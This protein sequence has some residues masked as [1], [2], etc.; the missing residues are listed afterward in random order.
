MPVSLR[1]GH[2]YTLLVLHPATA[3]HAV[4]HVCC[5]SRLDP[6][7]AGQRA[8]DRL[9]A[10]VPITATE[11]LFP[12]H[13]EESSRKISDPLHR[14]RNSSSRALNNNSETQHSS[15]TAP[16]R[17]VIPRNRPPEPPADQVRVFIGIFSALSPEG[18]RA[19]TKYDYAAR[20]NIAR[21]TWVQEA[22]QYDHMAVRFVVG[23]YPT[24]N[25]KDGSSSNSSSN[26]SGNATS[27]SVPSQQEQDSRGA[28]VGAVGATGVS[29]VSSG[30]A[31][32]AVATHRR[33]RTSSR[34]DLMQRQAL[35]QE[36]ER[37]GDFLQL[38]VQGEQCTARSVAERGTWYRSSMS[39][40]RGPLYV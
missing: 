26:E 15:T 31:S 12:S 32:A 30:G 25:S 20:R 3:C 1:L 10:H 22:V 4:K 39:C 27:S 38:D 28:G 37:E 5:C 24:S 17:V 21:A 35:V 11:T 33:R 19:F 34:P 2:A 40:R 16:Q 6:R 29:S 14:M 9:E 13:L 36:M 7:A 23:T 18:A 8:L